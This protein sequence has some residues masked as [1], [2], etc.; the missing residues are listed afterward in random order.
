MPTCTSTGAAR[1]RAAPPLCA[2]PHYQLT[3]TYGLTTTTVP[4]M[5]SSYIDPLALA[6]LVNLRYANHPGEPMS[7]TLIQVLKQELTPPLCGV[8][9]TQPCVY[10]DPVVHQQLEIYRLHYK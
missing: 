7:N 4:L 1:S 10:Q 6:R 9:G 3:E 2:D 8:D 5:S